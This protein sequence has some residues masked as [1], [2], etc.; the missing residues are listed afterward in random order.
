MGL[1]QF[2]KTLPRLY[3]GEHLNAPGVRSMRCHKLRI[4]AADKESLPVELDGEPALAAAIECR[5][6]PE[7]LGLQAPWENAVAV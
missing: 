4:E 6:L 5:V 7:A 1:V 2:C 3:R